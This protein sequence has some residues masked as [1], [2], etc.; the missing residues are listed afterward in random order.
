MSLTLGEKLRQAREQ[1]GF[2]LS[3]VA[4]Q[5]RISPQYLECIENND[6]SKLPGGIF[7]KGFVKSFAK[8][9]GINEQ[10]ALN[11]YSAIISSSETAEGQ[12]LKPYKPEVLTDDRTGNSMIPTVITAVV[13][14]GLMTAGILFL[15]DYLRRPSEPVSVNAP[16]QNNSN[17]GT[18]SPETNSETLTGAPTMATLK[19]EF[20]AI[21]QPVRLIATS[22]GTKSD[23]V[24]AAGSSA[25]FEPRESLTLNYNRWNAAAVELTINGKAI[26]LPAEPLRGASDKGRIEFTINKDNLAQIWSN[27]AISS[28]VPPATPSN[29]NANVAAPVTE[30]NTNVAATPPPASTPAP[31][32]PTPANT[33]ANRP[34]ANTNT[35]AR[36]T[37][38]PKPASTP[39]AAAPTA[40]PPAN[41]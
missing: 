29:S 21:G 30:S 14:L 22:D 41:N 20:K 15:V 7:N 28:E 32:R 40:K 16:V 5:T 27:G 11:D 36:P 12:D 26:T 37:P 10:E 35:A 4:E 9:V 39:A 3:E 17:T 34:A 6:Y 2:T 31:A 33:A 19:V 23:N 24:I 18:A 1:R 25:T 8:F 38:A 13:I